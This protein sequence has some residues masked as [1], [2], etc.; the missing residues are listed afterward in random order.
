MERR[1]NDSHAFE[2]KM[3]QQLSS[4]AVSNSFFFFFSIKL[5]ITF[6]F[7]NKIFQKVSRAQC[8]SIYNDIKQRRE[9]NSHIVTVV[10]RHCLA[11]LLNM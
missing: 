8:D 4:R 6:C 2:Q 3:L 1:Q 10:T 9:S 7:I 11:F 5:L